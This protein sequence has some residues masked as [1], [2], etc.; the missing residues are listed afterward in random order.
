MHHNVKGQ[1]CHFP[2]INHIYLIF[3][4]FVAGN[5]FFLPLLFILPFEESQ[6]TEKFYCMSHET[7]P[8]HTM[9][10]SQVQ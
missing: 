4:S 6:G 1:Q 9:E 5:L 3:P 7:G 8:S 2:K 10:K